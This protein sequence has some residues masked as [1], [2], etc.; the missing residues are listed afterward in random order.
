MTNNILYAVLAVLLAAA[1]GQIYL[2]VN[3]EQLQAFLNLPAL[4][5]L[6]GE[7]NLLLLAPEIIIALVLLYSILHLAITK[8]EEEREGVW[9]FAGVGCLSALLCLFLHMGLIGLQNP[10]G[11]SVMY[12]MFQND[13]FSVMIRMFLVLGT[14]LIV[15]YSRLY[16]KNRSELPGE[17]YTVI[18]TALLGGMLMSGARN[19]IMLFVALETLG[20]SSYIM[21]G[22]LRGNVRSAEAGLK[23]LVYGGMAT[24]IL[25]FGFSLLY[26]ITGQ[27]DYSAIAHHLALR[28]SHPLIPIMSVLILGGFAFKLSAAPFHMWTPDVYEGAP[29]PV[30]AFLSVVSKI[31]G[32]SVVIRFLSTFA[33]I[34]TFSVWFNVLVVLSLLSMVIGNV[35]ALTQTNVKR[36]LAYST[37]A[38]AGYLLLGLALIGN[39]QLSSVHIGPEGY[40]QLTV[41][42]AGLSSL[43][44]YLVAY[45]FMNV[46]A[47]AAVIYFGNLTN[48]S[49]D[50]ADYAGLV[51]K[52]PA[53]TLIFSMML[54]SLA[55]I[56]I[57]AGFYGKFFLFQ[58]VANAGGQYIWLVM[59]ALVTS[60]ISLY[61]YLNVIRLMVIAEP[62][63]VV[64][65]MPSET[66]TAGGSIQWMFSPTNLVLMFC[67]Y[68]TLFMGLFA[69]RF[70]DLSGVSVQSLTNNSYLY[71]QSITKPQTPNALSQLP[72]HTR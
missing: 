40:T 46:G 10:A 33:G 38:H 30:T 56:P 34:T 60:T 71:S 18:L 16:L 67:L 44:Y 5:F 54:L 12:G 66:E 11:E 2:I 4:R 41:A 31:A 7:L 37:I 43:V 64:E 13:L 36:L 57:T 48:G 51:Q 53:L 69:Q 17:F 50:I 59:V 19:L 68:G 23:Y 32:F 52:R 49:E 55:G 65:K 26:G 27:T 72:A 1:V 6:T 70:I 20:I 39:T 14:L 63:S 29:T 8:S 21:V 61:Y 42:Q 15:G 22:Y 9:M 35:V 28:D 45:L 47:F 58:A 62:S 3:P 25:L 24:A